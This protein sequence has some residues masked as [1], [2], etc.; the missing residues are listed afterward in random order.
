M[1][2]KE[3]HNLASNNYLVQLT[4]NLSFAILNAVSWANETFISHNRR[5]QLKRIIR[6]ME[7]AL[8][9]AQFFVHEKDRKKMFDLALT[10]EIVEQV[11]TIQFL[12]M[13]VGSEARDK[14]EKFC[15]ELNNE[16]VNQVKEENK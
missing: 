2:N 10:Q 11:A 1:N 3:K 6:R 14:I 4:Q 7:M 12:V 8:S 16:V 15:I 9:E 13:S 5:D